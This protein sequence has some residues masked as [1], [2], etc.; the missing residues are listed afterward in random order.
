MKNSKY[1][2]H[3]YAGTKLFEFNCLCDESY[4]HWKSNISEWLSNLH[5]DPNLV[6]SWNEIDNSVNI[7]HGERYKILLKL[8]SKR[9]LWLA[10]Y[11]S[12]QVPSL[13]EKVFIK[14]TK[15]LSKQG[16]NFPK[17]LDMGVNIITKKDTNPTHDKYHLW[18]RTTSDFLQTLIP[19]SGLS[20]EWL[21][22]PIVT[23]Y[24]KNLM[25]CGADVNKD[26]LNSVKERI[27]WLGELFNFKINNKIRLVED[28][29]SDFLRS[30]AVLPPIEDLIDPPKKIKWK[31]PKYLLAGKLREE[32]LKKDI[33]IK[34]YVINEA[35][36]YVDRRGNPI[37][38][39]KALGNYYVRR[40]LDYLETVDRLA[41]IDAIDD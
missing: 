25:I 34:E 20:A 15:K 13:D 38:G 16:E 23:Y 24:A 17:Y 8:I 10:K 31:K 22:L 40:K 30:Q 33:P 3:V 36:N 5:A 37:D 27:I 29:S 41:G 11:P 1:Y 26:L 32:A 21:A 28:M 9:F 6:V 7:G 4:S 18:L 39:E 2:E 19:D 12:E 14:L 35:M